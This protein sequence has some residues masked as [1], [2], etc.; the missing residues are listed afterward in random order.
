V[1]LLLLQLLVSQVQD[2]TAH[3]HEQQGQR[4][5]AHNA[6]LLQHHTISGRQIG[7]IYLLVLAPRSHKAQGALAIVQD[8]VVDLHREAGGIV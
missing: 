6:G 4:G 2:H 5:S 8:F 7:A 3:G 1:Q